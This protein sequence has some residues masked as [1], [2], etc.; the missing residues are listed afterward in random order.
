MFNSQSPSE[1]DV[2][3]AV[4]DPI[5]KAVTRCTKTIIVPTEVFVKDVNDDCLASIPGRTK[6]GPCEG[7]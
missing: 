3:I 1:S 2:R 7:G 4:I 6:D 5:V